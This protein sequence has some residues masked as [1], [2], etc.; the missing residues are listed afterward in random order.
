MNKEASTEQEIMRCFKQLMALP[1]EVSRL[2]RT[3]YEWKTVGR[4]KRGRPKN[5]LRRTYDRNLRTAGTSLIHEWENV[6]AA[7]PMQDEWR[8]FVDVLCATDGFGGTKA[9]YC[10]A[11]SL[12]N[13]KDQTDSDNHKAPKK[14]DWEK[15]IERARKATPVYQ[16]DASSCSSDSEKS[17]FAVDLQKVILFSD[18]PGVIFLSR[19]VVFNETFAGVNQFDPASVGEGHSHWLYGMKH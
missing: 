9:K 3:T 8:G 4:R 7:A 15:R 1:M 6:I 5:T 17:I 14:K 19:L 16:S 13:D 12:G 18:M 11:D 2:P 10:T